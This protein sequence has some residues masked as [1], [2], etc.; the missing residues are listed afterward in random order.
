M[1]LYEILAKWKWMTRFYWL[2]ACLRFNVLQV[3]NRRDSRPV[4]CLFTDKRIYRS[5]SHCITCRR[6]SFVLCDA[7]DVWWLKNVNLTCY[8][9][10]NQC[11]A[12][13]SRVHLHSAGST[14]A[15][16]SLKI[17]PFPFAA[18]ASIDCNIFMLDLELRP[19]V[20]VARVHAHTCHTPTCVMKNSFTN[21]WSIRSTWISTALQTIHF[22]TFQ[23]TFM[24]L[25]SQELK[26][27]NCNHTVTLVYRQF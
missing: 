18:D 2:K 3:Q 14:T 9:L 26:L 27:K 10:N 11:V 13:F 1:S 22:Q 19:N 25:Q 23:N 24:C 4:S 15:I 7:M 20:L 21:H 5:K 16:S 8:L 6:C 17:C 12:K